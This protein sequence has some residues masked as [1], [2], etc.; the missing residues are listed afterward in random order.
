[1][2]PPHFSDIEISIVAIFF[3]LFLMEQLVC[4]LLQFFFLEETMLAHQKCLIFL[5]E[6]IIS[7]SLYNNKSLN[8]PLNTTI[9]TILPCIHTLND[10][11]TLNSHLN[12]STWQ[13]IPSTH[14]CILS[15]TACIN[16]Q[17]GILPQVINSIRY[18]FFL[19]KKS[20]KRHGILIDFRKQYKL[21][22]SL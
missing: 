15:V 13:F 10:E 9:Y 18:L 8:S 7:I 11:G 16:F 20:R 22:P 3:L 2:I 4:S 21:F 19:K 6:C 5:K 12:M 1:M 14:V 17:G